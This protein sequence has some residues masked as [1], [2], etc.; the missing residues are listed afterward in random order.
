MNYLSHYYFD[1]DDDRP[2]YILGLILPDLVRTFNRER[3]QPQIIE[4]H[5]DVP[6]RNL[7]E[8]VNK[9]HHIDKL[10]HSSNFFRTYNKKTFKQLQQIELEGITKYR[11]FIS[12]VLIEMLLDRLLLKED[13]NTAFTFYYKLNATDKLI[14]MNYFNHIPAVEGDLE[15]L[16]LFF[17]RFCSSEFLY[18]YQN[19]EGLILRL[20]GVMQRITKQSFTA[21]DKV[22]LSLFI[23]GLEGELKG[24]YKGIFEELN[25]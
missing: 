25:F 22:K 10:F 19:N 3:L 16:W 21:T 7:Q 5:W 23:D 18:D 1:K 6:I 15:N 14:F 24:V 13:L 11:H 2:H 4:T 12:H 9:H 20:G 8:G 17:Q